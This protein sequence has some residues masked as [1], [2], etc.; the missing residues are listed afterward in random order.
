M[1]RLM[2]MRTSVP[3]LLCCF[4]LAGCTGTVAL[5]VQP[6]ATLAPG[7]VVTGNFVRVGGPYPG[8]A[9]P[10]SGQLDFTSSSHTT[11]VQVARDGKFTAHLPPGSYTLSGTS[12]Q[13]ISGS[14]P[15]SSPSEFALAAGQRLTRDVVCHIR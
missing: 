7:G 4:V 2:T 5:K 15:C 9:V 10:L 6:S 3:A 12:P 14:R 11:I 13:I 8:A 1:L